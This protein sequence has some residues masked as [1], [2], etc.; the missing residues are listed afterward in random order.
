MSVSHLGKY[1]NTNR[2]SI[3]DN[4]TIDKTYSLQDFLY[5][6][7]IVCA[8][9]FSQQVPEQIKDLI[10]LTSSPNITLLEIGFNAGH[11][12]EL[13]L[14]N[15]P[16]L[17]VTS[18]DIGEHEYYKKGKEYIDCLYPERLTLII[19]D[20]TFIIPFYTLS[21]PGKTFD[22]IF[23]D[24]GHDYHIA[25]ADLMNCR[26]LAHKDT[27]LILD[28]TV[29]TPKYVMSHTL[30]PTKVWKEA[31]EQGVITEIN[32]GDYTFGRGMSWGKYVFH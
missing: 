26:K 15:N 21:N 24:G 16:L 3:N 7:N 13:F 20:S 1:T 30:G 11:S 18:F 31:I 5:E 4:F 2:R 23:I 12:S 27:I 19:G 8:E 6:N 22:I 10:K 14:K 17:K 25:Y 9:G 32:H 28:D 29:F